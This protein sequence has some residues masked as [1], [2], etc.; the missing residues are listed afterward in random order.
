MK[1][2]ILLN[3]FEKRALFTVV[4]VSKYPLNEYNFVHE[5][6]KGYSQV[7]HLQPGSILVIDNTGYKSGKVT[8]FDKEVF[9]EKESNPQYLQ[10]KNFALSELLMKINLKNVAI[11]KNAYEVI[12][13]NIYVKVYSLSKSQFSTGVFVNILICLAIVAVIIKA[14]G[15]LLRSKSGFVG[16][17]VDLLTWPLRA[18]G[19][20][21]GSNGKVKFFGKSRNNKANLTYNE[22]GLLEK[23]S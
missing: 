3:D 21:R 7:E 14:K 6:L 15:K 16:L 10:P 5:A 12:K 18:I 11:P 22:V 4:D 2:E 1:K 17:A 8:V 13:S 19:L 23:S 9:A 20:I